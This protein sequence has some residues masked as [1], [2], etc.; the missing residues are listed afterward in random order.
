MENL[1]IA[2]CAFVLCMYVAYQW[3]RWMLLLTRRSCACTLNF[4]L[5]WTQWSPTSSPRR[6]IRRRFCS[7]GMPFISWRYSVSSVS[8]Y[9]NSQLAQWDS[10]HLAYFTTGIMP[11]VSHCQI[12]HSTRFVR[13][14]GIIKP[15]PNHTTNPNPNPKYN[16]NRRNKY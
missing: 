13:H 4:L 1:V 8:Q 6:L 10:R 15:K 3:L 11:N 12:T 16:R 7:P 14:V 9:H 5:Q 2:C